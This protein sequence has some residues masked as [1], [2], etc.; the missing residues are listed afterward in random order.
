MKTQN[1]GQMSKTS[2]IK[3]ELTAHIT[4]AESNYSRIEPRLF[5]FHAFSDYSKEIPV[6]TGTTMPMPSSSEPQMHNFLGR[7]VKITVEFI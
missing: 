1:I 4:E 6:A 2:P 5:K 3:Y 7:K